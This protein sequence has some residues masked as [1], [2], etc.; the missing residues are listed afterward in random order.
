MAV[1]ASFVMATIILGF[2]KPFNDPFTHKMEYFNEIVLLL[3]LYCMMCFSDFVPKVETQ[4]EIGWL[5]CFVV[6]AHFV[7]NVYF[8]LKSNFHVLNLR[9]KKKKLI[10]AHKR[11]LRNRI[12]TTP[13]PEESN[14]PEQL[15]KYIVKVMKSVAMTTPKISN[16]GVKGAQRKAASPQKLIQFRSVKLQIMSNSL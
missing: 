4:F 12:H 5:C 2:T 1:V 6:T 7:I 14:E 11:Q 15:S 10:R 9:C 13:K 8:M 3:T 16:S